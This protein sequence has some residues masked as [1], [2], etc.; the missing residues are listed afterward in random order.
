MVIL[1]G[2]SKPA[3][4]IVDATCHPGEDCT[5]AMPTV[6]ITQNSLSHE[7]QV[8][9]ELWR[10]CKEKHLSFKVWE[11]NG[12]NAEAWDNR[13]SMIEA[14]G[15]DIPRWAIFQVFRDQGPTKAAEDLLEA[16]KHGPNRGKQKNSQQSFDTGVV[17]P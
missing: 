10:V 6:E 3:P 16:L 12:A 9:A 13:Y 17:N 5:A 14:L 2:C 15:E 4:K 11:D 1:V 7:A 8:Y